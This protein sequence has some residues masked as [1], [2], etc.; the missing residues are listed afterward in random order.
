MKQIFRMGVVTKEAKLTH[1]SIL[2]WIGFIKEGMIETFVL[3]MN[4][5]AVLS[6]NLELQVGSRDRFRIGYREIDDFGRDCDG[7]QFSHD[8]WSMF[9]VNGAAKMD[10]DLFWNY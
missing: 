10:R 9:K 2:A 8:S 5:D 7:C 1:G 3:A 4:T 6:K